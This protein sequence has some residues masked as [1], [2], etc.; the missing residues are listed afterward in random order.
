MA[1]NRFPDERCYSRSSLG[2]ILGWS[3]FSPAA[4]VG[5]GKRKG[6]DLLS[7]PI[8]G[9]GAG[10]ILSTRLE[11]EFC[12]AWSTS[13]RWEVGFFSLD[14]EESSKRLLITRLDTFSLQRKG[15]GSWKVDRVLAN[16]SLFH[17]RGYT[18]HF[19]HSHC[20]VSLGGLHRQARVLLR[21]RAHGGESFHM[22]PSELL[23]RILAP[24]GSSTKEI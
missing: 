20:L 21:D 19:Q 11:T 1:Q 13:H 10:K 12:R 2:I 18:G 3:S 16:Q 4:F 7:A 23:E 15:M 9:D 8:S 17:D 24:V 14:G 22:K 5:G 6:K